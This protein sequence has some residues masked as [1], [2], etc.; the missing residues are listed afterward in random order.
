MN[1]FWMG[2]VVRVT[3]VMQVLSS[4]KGKILTET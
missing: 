4:P 3:D 2:V 1:V